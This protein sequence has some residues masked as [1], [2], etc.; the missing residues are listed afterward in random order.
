MAVNLG[1]HRHLAQG[2]PEKNSTKTKQP[3]KDEVMNYH[4]NATHFYI[5]SY[6]TCDRIFFSILQHWSIEK[7]HH[8]DQETARYEN[9]QLT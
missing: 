2:S 1:L 6:I 5:G 4:L 3:Y 9:L 8:D 7:K